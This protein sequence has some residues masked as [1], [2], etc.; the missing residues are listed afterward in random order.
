MESEMAELTPLTEAELDALGSLFPAPN[1]DDMALAAKWTP[2]LIAELRALREA[3]R[4]AVEDLDLEFGHE[5]T[6]S[7][8][9]RDLLPPPVV[10]LYGS[11]E[12]G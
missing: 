6:S 2:R 3:A 11:G 1:D 10:A 12:R 5:V 7:R 9:L 8:A 4:L